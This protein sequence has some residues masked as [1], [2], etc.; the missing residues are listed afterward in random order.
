MKFHH[1]SPSWK[2]VLANTGKNTIDHPLEK[3]L[4][5]PMDAMHAIMDRTRF[6]PLP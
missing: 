5:T 1:F 6:D 4:P 2:I 3:I